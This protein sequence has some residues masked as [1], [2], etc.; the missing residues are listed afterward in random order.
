MPN[1][2]EIPAPAKFNLTLDVLQKLPN[3]YHS[4]EMIMQTIDIYDVLTVS[5]T[6][7]PEIHLH[8]NKELPDKIPPEKNLYIKQ[9]R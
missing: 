5:I 7:S 6:G 8:M 1:T 4:L 2:L 9:L 3:G